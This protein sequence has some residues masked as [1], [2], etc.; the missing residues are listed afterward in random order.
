[1]QH[2][3]PNLCKKN[4]VQFRTF[5]VS[6]LLVRAVAEQLV[7]HLNQHDFL[8]KFHSAYRQGLSCETTT[9]RILND[10]LCSE[11]GGDSVL[12]VLLDLSAV[13]DTTDHKIRL[14]RL[15]NEVGIASTAYQ[16]FCSYLTN[17][18]QHVTVNQS[19][20]ENRPLRCGVPQGSVL[21][22]ILFSLYTAQ[23]GRI[24]EKRDLC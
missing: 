9:L 13:F 12:L 5:L 11:G 1:M 21:G 2:D 3:D 15:H 8:D 23:P 20:S 14:M 10:A 18:T 6:K 19:F 16:W 7:P 4:V 17:R 24:M 22:P